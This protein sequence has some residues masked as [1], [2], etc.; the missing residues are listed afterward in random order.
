[1]VSISRIDLVQNLRNQVTGSVLTADDADY[2]KTRR[3]WSLT[4]NHYPTVILVAKNAGD[5]VAGVRFAAE[6]GLGVSIQSTGHGFNNLLI[7]LCSL[8]P[9]R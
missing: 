6:A 5:V 2:D 4:V 9:L 8:L 7:T 1:M 3:G